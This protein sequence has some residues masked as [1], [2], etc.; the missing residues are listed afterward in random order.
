MSQLVR[1]SVQLSLLILNSSSFSREATIMS[2]NLIDSKNNGIPALMVPTTLRQVSPDKTRTDHSHTNGHLRFSRTPSREEMRAVFLMC[3]GNQWNSVLDSIR[4]NILIQTTNMTMDNNIS[5]TIIHQ[6]I[7]SKGDINK[8]AIVIREILQVTPH[9]ASIKNG[10]GS[11]PLHVICQRNVKMNSSMKEILIRDLINAYPG[12]LTVQGGVGKRTP[13]HIIFTDYVSAEVTEFMIQYGRGAC[14]MRDKNGFL[15]AHVACSRHCSPEKLKMLLDVNPGSL[16]EKTNDG[17]TPLCL[18]KSKATKSHPNY[19]LITD[20][21]TRV[22][23]ASTSV[24]TVTTQYQFQPGLLNYPESLGQSTISFDSATESAICFNGSP[25][26]RESTPNRNIKREN[27]S[28]DESQKKIK[29]EER[30]PAALNSP[31][32]SFQENKPNHNI[33]RENNSSDNDSQ[34]RTNQ[35]ESDP[36]VN[37]L[38][39]FSRHTDNIASV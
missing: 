23:I 30:N 38:L 37:L 26:F 32:P 18:A 13:L 24:A 20:I 10:Y 8:R 22:K 28:R 11:L 33:K 19:A 16:F 3:R 34:E 27:T 6:A 7:T 17:R 9:A 4:S 5:T 31:F 35:E 29:Q 2:N 25:R 12:S 36:A 39:H 1:H 21:E 14:F 15:P